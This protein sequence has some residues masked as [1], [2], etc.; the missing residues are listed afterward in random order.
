MF[1]G[2]AVA[3]SAQLAP[4]HY[5]VELNGTNVSFTPEGSDKSVTTA[6]KVEN[7]DKKFEMTAAEASNEGNITHVHSIRLG[8]TKLRLIF[9]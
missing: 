8:G 2:P 1:S 4:G 6:A 3:G 9:E 7:S 5:K